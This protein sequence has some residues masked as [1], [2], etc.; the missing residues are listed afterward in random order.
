MELEQVLEWQ[1]D[2]KNRYLK[3]DSKLLDAY[4]TMLDGGLL[5]SG[6]ANAIA[7]ALELR[8]KSSPD[9]IKALLVPRVDV[10]QE[11]KETHELNIKITAEKVRQLSEEEVG[12]WAAGGPLPRIM[13]E[14]IE[15]IIEGEFEDITDE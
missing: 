4:E 7:K 8:L 15:D 11:T 10:T 6:T 9:S 5:P 1:A 13:S 12:D 2:F 14:T 3:N